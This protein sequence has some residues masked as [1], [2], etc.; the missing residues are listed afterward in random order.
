M[1]LIPILKTT[2]VSVLGK[3]FGTAVRYYWFQIKLLSSDSI[4]LIKMTWF[5]I[6]DQTN[7]KV[8]IRN[9]TNAKVIFIDNDNLVTV[10]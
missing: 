6:R 2:V 4:E 1:L 7:T 10:V 3:N 5:L 9:H 8:M